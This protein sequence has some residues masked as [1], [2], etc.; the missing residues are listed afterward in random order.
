MTILNKPESVPKVI[1]YGMMI[2]TNFNEKVDPKNQSK[3]VKDPKNENEK[4]AGYYIMEKYD[5]NLE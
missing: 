3:K 4:I 1:D 5:M 2:I